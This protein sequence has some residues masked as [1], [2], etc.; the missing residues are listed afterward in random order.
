MQSMAI[1]IKKHEFLH[2][3]LIAADD[4]FAS[5]ITPELNEQPMHCDRY[6]KSSTFLS[7]L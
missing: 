2:K 6:N 3:K 5:S 1:I 7:L 4:S